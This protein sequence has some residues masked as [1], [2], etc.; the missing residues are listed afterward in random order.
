[1]LSHLTLFL[2]QKALAKHGENMI[3]Y[4]YTKQD[5]MKTLGQ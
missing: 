3:C 2:K 4:D 1:M 5:L